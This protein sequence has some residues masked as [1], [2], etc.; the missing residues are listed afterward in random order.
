[1]LGGAALLALAVMVG[2]ES[3]P[4]MKKSTGRTVPKAEVPVPSTATSEKSGDGQPA[5]SHKSVNRREL[6]EL[7]SIE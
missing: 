2:C 4:F 1:M 5:D 6:D 7:L 3:R